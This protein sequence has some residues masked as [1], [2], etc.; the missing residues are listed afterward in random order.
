MKKKK[1][2]ASFKPKKN[3]KTDRKSVITYN[4]NEYQS[5]N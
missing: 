5:A 2:K 3:K 4:E 1:K